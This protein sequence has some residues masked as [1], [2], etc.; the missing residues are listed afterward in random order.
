MNK[1]LTN[2]SKV[3]IAYLASVTLRAV[4]AILGGGCGGLG[5][6]GQHLPD[7]FIRR[8]EEPTEGLVLRRVEFPQCK[9]PFL[10]REDQA[11]DHDLDYVGKPDWL[12]HQ[13]LDA[14]LQPSHFFLVAPRQACL[15]PGHEPRGGSGSELRGRDPF[16]IAGLGDVKPPSLPPL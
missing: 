2:L 8:V 3:W 13:G 14:C 15:F 6:F 16:R 5:A 9:I 1:S 7:V 12:V 11:N 4:S 10:A